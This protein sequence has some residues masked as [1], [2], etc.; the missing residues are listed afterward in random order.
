MDFNAD[1]FLPENVAKR[2]NLT[3]I[4]FSYG[5]RN[6]IAHKYAIY[7][8]KTIVAQLLKK[9]RFSTTLKMDDLRFGFSITIN[10]KNKHMM[11]IERR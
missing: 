9:Y 3:Y 6:C 10:L 4:P 8:L 11:S 7:A 1:N 5:Q 2:Q